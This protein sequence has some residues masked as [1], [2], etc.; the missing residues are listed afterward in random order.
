MK[1]LL[2]AVLSVLFAA[3]I[4]MPASMISAEE[5]FTVPEGYDAYD[6]SKLIAFLEQEDEN[7]V[8]NGEKVSSIYNP[9]DPDTLGNVR[10]TDTEVKHLF[11]VG[12]SYNI[13][14]VTQKLV[15]ILD[16]SG[17]TGL[18]AV[19]CSRNMLTALDLSGCTA[20]EYVACGYNELESIDLSGCSALRVL[21]CR[22]NNIKALELDECSDLNFID[23]I[24]NNLSSLDFSSSP[25]IVLDG[26]ESDGRGFVGFASY[27]SDNEPSIT[28]EEDPLYGLGSFAYASPAEGWLF[29]GWY[30]RYGTL[31]SRS[32]LFGLMGNTVPE[33]VARFEIG[34][35]GDVDGNTE[36]D[37]VDALLTM[38]YAL[39]L[40]EFTPQQIAAAD[41]NLDGEVNLSDA[42]L[43]LRCAVGLIDSF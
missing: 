6:Y 18:V 38:R 27:L 22:Y 21:W 34:T 30:T 31:V 42:L 13:V 29:V 23:C 5:E 39:E 33:L 40:T 17:C 12:Y 7:G 14:L 36:I 8:K 19:R 2:A 26:L 28:G 3:V 24:S 41:V 10:W 11:Y 32:R 37:I 43:I 35:L 9:N 16:L 25:Y 1:K 4:L 15:G 20:L